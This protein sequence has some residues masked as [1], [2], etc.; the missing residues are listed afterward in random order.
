[1][2][3]EMAPTIGR[4][5]S[6]VSIAIRNPIPFLPTRAVAGTKQ[7]S[8]MI[9]DVADALIPILSSSLPIVT[10]GVFLSTINT[11]S[12]RMPPN[13]LVFAKRVILSAIGALVMKHFVP[14]SR[15]P[16]STFFALHATAPASD[17]APGSVSAK[18]AMPPLFRQSKYSFFC[19]SEP[20]TT[21]GKEA[22]ELAAQ[23]VATPAHPFAISSV[24]RATVRRSSPGP[25]YSAGTARVVIP[26]CFK[27]LRRSS[28]I[29]PLLS[30]SKAL[31]AISFSLISLANPISSCCLAV[32][33]KSILY[34]H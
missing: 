15:Y 11:V 1:M 12:P 16:P 29:T 13:S 5:F 24:A 19:S 10:P 26:D 21:T 34:L 7:S 28:S 2:P 3:T 30:I 17:P 14:L 8:R 32:S 27:I 22:K 31:G 25:P 23:T 6:K 4:D 18:H 33:E 20:A 9:S